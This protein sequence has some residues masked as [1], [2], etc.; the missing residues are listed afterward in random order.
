LRAL[1][2]LFF[3][4]FVLVPH[5]ACAVEAFDGKWIAEIPPQ[6]K[7]CNG[8]SVLEVV[9]ANGSLIGQVHTPWGYSAFTGKLDVDGSGPISFGN[10]VGMIHFSGDHF[11]VNWSN[12]RCGERTALGD[13]APSEAQVKA[14]ADQRR[15]YQETFDNLVGRANTGDAR[16]DYT[17]L[18]NAYPFTEQWDPFGNKTA[19]L[20]REAEA[21]RNGGDCA[22]A[23]E[24][25]EVVLKY[26]F[27]IDSAHALRADCI[28][29]ANPSQAQIENIIADGLIH[30]LMDSGDGTSEKTAYIVNTMREEQDVLA[31]R[32]IQLKTRHTEVRGSNGH[33]YDVVDG[34]SIR[35]P[36]G[37]A[38]GSGQTEALSRTVYF[39][40]G[41]I[42]SGRMSRN[43]AATI[44]STAIH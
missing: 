31:N 28:A 42:V 18:R 14:I 13:R 32:N 22:V 41:S 25:L 4:G 36:S 7:P 3:I 6:E 21:A 29:D 9:V 11:E 34:L 24:K 43:A 15:Q 38:Q 26:D 16:V 33:Y 8:T 1:L 17:A 27:T 39:D 19:T 10:E 12:T 30:S 40:V 44:A 20:L 37:E 5:T 2:V 23:L 35:K